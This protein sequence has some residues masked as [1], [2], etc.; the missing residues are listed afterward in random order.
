MQELSY[1]SAAFAARRRSD[2]SQYQADEIEDGIGHNAILGMSAP[3]PCA[4]CVN[5]Q[6]ADPFFDEP[7]SEA[8]AGAGLL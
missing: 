7:E 5:L 3:H 2:S 4:A 1:A 6:L 8:E